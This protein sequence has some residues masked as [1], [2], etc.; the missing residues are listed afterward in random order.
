M[1]A[2][3]KTLHRPFALCRCKLHMCRLL[4]KHIELF[5]FQAASRYPLLGACE[6]EGDW[7]SR[8]RVH[9]SR[10]SLMHTDTCIYTFMCQC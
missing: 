7:E 2:C 10:F 1:R 4:L 8:H 5:V 6:D 3:C 9:S